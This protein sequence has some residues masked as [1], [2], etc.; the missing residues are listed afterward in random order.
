MPV[1]N[2]LGKTISVTPSSTFWPLSVI[3]K[4]QGVEVKVN[5]E[6]HWWCLWIC[7]STDD[8]DAIQCTVSLVSVLEDQTVTVKSSCSSCGDLTV[9]GDA[10]WGY[11]APWEFQRA[12]FEGTITVNGNHGAFQGSVPL[13]Q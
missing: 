6:R 7:T 12:D 5:P 1:F 13:N 10:S 9:E 11:S 4:R 2:V 3:Y 8:V